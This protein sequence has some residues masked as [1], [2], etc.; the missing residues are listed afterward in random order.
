MILEC[1][2]YSVGSDLFYLCN[3][4]LGKYIFFDIICVNLLPLK[5]LNDIIPMEL[6]R[7]REVLFYHTDVEKYLVKL[8]KNGTRDHDK[9]SSLILKL[10]EN[11]YA[12][13][14]LLKKHYKIL[15][16]DS[17][18]EPN[19]IQIKIPT[20]PYRIHAVLTDKYTYLINAFDKKQNKTPVNALSTS[21]KRARQI[22]I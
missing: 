7:Q 17:S 21:K 16:K 8:N 3:R 4:R 2:R 9:L 10:N 11:G 22:H 19:I 12:I 1:K 20:K 18:N 6:R 13:L 15:E 14:N 5:N